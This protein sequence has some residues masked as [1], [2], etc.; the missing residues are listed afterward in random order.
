MM[1]APPCDPDV[2][3]LIGALS[4]ETRRSGDDEITVARA[5]M[6][7]LGRC[8]DE[9]A[10]RQLEGIL[11]KHKLDQDWRGEAARQLVK[12][13]G[14]TGADAVARS[15]DIEADL[16]T[17]LRFIRALRLSSEAATPA[18]RAALCTA[19]ETTELA[20]EARASLSSL[21]A[22]DDRRCP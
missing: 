5:A 18:V 20:S 14:A 17:A 6:A 11:R 2:S 7:A 21:F 15:L 1:P 19:T 22:G 10:A 12:H 13:Y 16:A 3:R 4:D 9:G 8:E